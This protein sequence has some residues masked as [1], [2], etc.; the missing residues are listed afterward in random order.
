MV[1]CHD[2]ISKTQVLRVQCNGFAWM[3]FME[4][5]NNLGDKALFL[6]ILVA[7]IGSNGGRF[8]AN[9]AHRWPAIGPGIARQWHAGQ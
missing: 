5:E 3:R 4:I 6:T 2:P 9:R 1:H 8:L 7:A